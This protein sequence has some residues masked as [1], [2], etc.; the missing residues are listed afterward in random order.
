MGR[1]L[2]AMFGG[3]LGAVVAFFI[4]L[5]LLPPSIDSLEADAAALVL[6]E[7]DIVTIGSNTGATMIV[8]WECWST[9]EF[10]DDRS[11]P[12]VHGQLAQLV[13]ELGWSVDRATAVQ[14]G[15]VID[16]SRAL[17]NARITVGPQ[18]A[19]G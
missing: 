5:T 15:L 14:S 1:V 2:E 10:E 11:A 13:R 17:T 18:V 4:V 6:P 9:A 8:G 7:S 16:A 19:R 12:A 3:F